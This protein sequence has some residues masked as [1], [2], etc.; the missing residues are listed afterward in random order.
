MIPLLSCS[1]PSDLGQGQDGLQ[2][3]HVRPEA[4]NLVL[5]DSASSFQVPRLPSYSF[6]LPPPCSF[7]TFVVTEINEEMVVNAN[8]KELVVFLSKGFPFVIV[9][10]FLFQIGCSPICFGFW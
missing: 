6:L 7:R 4:V 8:S 3:Y 1:S 9:K 2:E 10:S 5:I